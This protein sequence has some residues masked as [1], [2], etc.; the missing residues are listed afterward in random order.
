MNKKVALLTSYVVSNIPLI[1]FAQNTQ[2]ANPI[3]ANNVVD[4]LAMILDVV[5][6]VSIPV[7]VLAFVWTGFKFVAAQGNPSKIEAAKTNLWYSL[8]GAGI[9]IGIKVILAIIQGT[10]SQLQ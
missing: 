8:L 6:V 2:L 9:I 3:R 4:L 10:I 5:I 7:L 1:V